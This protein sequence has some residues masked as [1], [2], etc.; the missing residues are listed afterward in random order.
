MCRFIRRGLS[1]VFILF[2]LP[3]VIILAYD[4]CY[5]QSKLQSALESSNITSQAYS[6]SFNNLASFYFENYLPVHV[7]ISLNAKSPSKTKSTLKI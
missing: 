5:F 3:I 1:I 2:C 6:P 7:A 4:I